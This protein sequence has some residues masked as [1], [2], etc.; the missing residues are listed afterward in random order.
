[1]YN[2]E[3]VAA[4]PKIFMGL[5]LVHFQKYWLL[6]QKLTER[7]AT[8]SS[9]ILAWSLMYWIT[10]CC[11]F[12]NCGL[13]VPLGGRSHS[14]LEFWPS[15]GESTSLPLPV[16]KSASYSSPNILSAVIDCL[17]HNSS[18]VPESWMVWK[19][20]Y[21]DFKFIFI[22]IVKCGGRKPGNSEKKKWLAFSMQ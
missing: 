10:L 13:A 19:K 15:E 5:A 21:T 17:W 20:N 2:L 18:K 22:H 1:M 6:R 9:S 3:A 11:L 8:G 12:D 4:R 16:T 14:G 7:M